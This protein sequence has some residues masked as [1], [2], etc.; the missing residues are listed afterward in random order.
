MTHFIDETYHINIISIDAGKPKTSL[1]S[2]NCDSSFMAALWNQAC[3]PCEQGL[4]CVTSALR[5]AVAHW[6]EYREKTCTY[7][8]ENV[9]V[10]TQV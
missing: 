10:K 1:D 6:Q 5:A 7:G 8:R 2:L 4:L 3:S 9:L